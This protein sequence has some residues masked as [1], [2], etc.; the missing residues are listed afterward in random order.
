M[1]NP[2]GAD[3]ERLWDIRLPLTAAEAALIDWVYVV[4]SWDEDWHGRCQA[5]L[6]LRLKLSLCF[7]NGGI[8]TLDQ[9]ELEDLLVM[10][11][12]WFQLG[13][14][15]AGYSLKKKLYVLLRGESLVLE[16]QVAGQQGGPAEEPETNRPGGGEDSEPSA[17]SG[18]Y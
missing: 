4:H 12:T 14:E 8:L 3:I 16:T 9:D 7:E 10:V 17:Y 5:R 18:T 1:E 13:R 6:S 11:P 2:D 15:D